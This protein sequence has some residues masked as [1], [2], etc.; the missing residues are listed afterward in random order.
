MGR[1]EKLDLILNKLNIIDK[2][3]IK[4]NDNL[5][6]IENKLKKSSLDL[7][8]T[9]ANLEKA[10]QSSSKT[11]SELLKSQLMLKQMED[12]II[13]YKQSSS[14]ITIDIKTASKSAKVL[15]PTLKNSERSLQKFE[16]QVT[17][18]NEKMVTL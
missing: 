18:L 3:Q 5:K 9:M 8:S 15:E 17:L 12:Q 7:N 16:E 13:S 14:D 4:L 6:D 10:N 1:Q 11:S 2:N